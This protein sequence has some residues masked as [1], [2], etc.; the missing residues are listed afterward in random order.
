[1]KFNANWAYK[2]LEDKA[3]NLWVGSYLGGVHVIHKDHALVHNGDIL[4]DKAYNST[5][6]FPN[7]LINQIVIDKEGDKWILFY[8]DW[9][10]IK[11]EN[12]SDEISAYN[13]R[14]QLDALPMLLIT[15][16]DDRLWCAF[17]GGIALLDKEGKQ[18]QKIHFSGNG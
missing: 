17:Q 12:Y 11:I 1:G 5:N 15:D 7:N 14:E 10:L 6:G 2:I 3:H 16:P 18:L 4:A 13:L 8:K 9:H